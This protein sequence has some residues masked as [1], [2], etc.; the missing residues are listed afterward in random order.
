M[1]DLLRTGAQRLLHQAIEAEMDE[2]LARYAPQGVGEG[3]AVVR[4]GHLPEREVVTGLGPI[5]VRVPKVRSRTAERVVFRSTL[6]PPYVRRSRTLDAALPWLYLKGIST[7][8]MREALEVLVGPQ[9]KGLSASVVSRLKGQWYGEYVAWRH[10]RLDG[11]RWVY[12]WADGIYCGLRGGAPTAVPAGGDRPE[13]PGRE[14][15][16]GDRGWGAGVY[17]ELA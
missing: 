5:A 12:C 16:S 6:V 4:N 2:L 7:G 8:Q 15:F 11:E 14:A 9:A 13:R 3:R 17:P 10:R 1:T